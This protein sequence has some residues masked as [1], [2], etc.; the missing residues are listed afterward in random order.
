MN[1]AIILVDTLHVVSWERSEESISRICSHKPSVITLLQHINLI[2]LTQFQLIAIYRSVIE[3]CAI[4][5]K[6]LNC[7][8]HKLKHLMI[9]FALRDWFISSVNV[10]H[11][12]FS[13]CFGF[14]DYVR[15]WR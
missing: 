14:A 3:H 1:L 11:F 10:Q 5:A 8:C 7:I 9:S 6:D 4:T 2:A 15:V 12:G 13:N